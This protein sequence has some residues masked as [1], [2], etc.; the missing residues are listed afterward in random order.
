M[1]GI[2]GSDFIFAV[3][4]N[5]D[6]THHPQGRNGV[7][8]GEEARRNFALASYERYLY[9]TPDATLRVRP[10][11]RIVRAFSFDILRRRLRRL[12]DL[13]RVWILGRKRWKPS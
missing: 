10:E 6:Y 9:G 7:V 4:Q 1:D 5:H 2:N 13:L 3:H 11:D 12:P 8:Q